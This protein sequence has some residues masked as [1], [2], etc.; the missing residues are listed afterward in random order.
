M[1]AYIQLNIYKKIKVPGRPGINY[2][3]NAEKGYTAAINL[4]NLSLLSYTQNYSCNLKRLI[5]L[6]HRWQLDGTNLV[7]SIDMALSLVSLLNAPQGLYIVKYQLLV[8]IFLKARVDCNKKW[9]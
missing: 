1:L 6:L 4:Q 5:I 3:I 2:V 7:L 9:I 8:K